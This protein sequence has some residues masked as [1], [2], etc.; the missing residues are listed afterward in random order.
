MN[1]CLMFFL[2]LVISQGFDLKNGFIARVG[3][4]FVSFFQVLSF[5]TTFLKA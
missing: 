1:M 2:K 5:R 4:V 3:F